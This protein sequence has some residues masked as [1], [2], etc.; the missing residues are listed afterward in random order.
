MKISMNWMLDHVAT[1]LSTLDVGLIV[2][3]FN[4]HTAEIES[5]EKFDLDLQNLFLVRIV[6]V[7]QSGLSVVCDELKKTIQLSFRN[8]VQVGQFVFIR[9]KGESFLWE[10]LQ[11][12][13]SSKEGLFPAV[14]CPASLVAGGW[15]QS[16]EDTDFILDVDNKSINHRPDLWGHRGI[17][18]EVAAFMGWQLKPLD[19]MLAQVPQVNYE[20]TATANVEHSLNL[21]IKDAAAS[22]RLAALYCG[23]ITHKPSTIWMAMRLARVDSKPI[24]TIVD[25]TNYVMFDISQPMHVFDAANF[26]DKKLVVRTAVTHE[27]LELLDGH[28]VN[29]TEHDIVVTDGV[30]PVALAGVMGGKLASFNQKATSIIIE[31]GSFQAAMV[32]NS[33]TRAKVATESATRFSKQL[34]PMQNTTALLRFVALAQELG[35]VGFLQEKLVSVGNVIHPAVI[36]VAHSFIE[37]RLGIKITSQEIR[38]NLEKLEFHVQEEQQPDDIVYHVTVPTFRITKDITIPEDIVEEIARLY[39][40]ENIVY[41][42]PTRQMKPFD[43]S[44]VMRLRKIKEHCAFA[45]KMAEVRDYLFYDESFLKR[46]GWYPTDAVAIKNPVSENWKVLVTSLIP[47]LIKNVELN[48]HAHEQLNFFEHN[49]VWREHSKEQAIEHKSLAGIFFGHKNMNFYDYKAQLQQLFAMLD[50]SVVWAKSS[51]SIEPWFDQLQVADIM[52]DGV[53]IGRAGMLS[54]P[55]VRSVIKG[56]GFVFEL[57]A[58]LLINYKTAAKKFV[59]WSKYQTVA[60]DISMLVDVLISAEQ[61]ESLILQADSKVDQVKLLDY[62]EKDEWAGKRSLTF[63]YRICDFEQNLTKEVIESITN[64]VITLMEKQ[65]ATIR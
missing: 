41:Q 19:Q 9:R 44:C 32:R 47:H 22:P 52:L 8:D 33:A 16:C 59:P 39:G 50:F 36:A 20:V 35:V 58:D 51:D 2:A 60:V 26:P 34:D 61:L 12:Y 4:V 31:A 37:K 62:F 57:H 40:F 18:R 1:T 24:N 15:K 64:K 43:M 17:A 25:T 11:Q 10:T 49:S 63:R 38:K 27:K 3:K 14:D 5:Y 45:M 48:H 6:S 7:D 30:K 46:L 23:E 56:S 54:A 53:K 65:G 55:F 29:L 21:E 42:R 28:L 13:S